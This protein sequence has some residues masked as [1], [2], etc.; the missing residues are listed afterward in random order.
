M[1]V[2]P[3]PVYRIDAGTTFIRPEGIAMAGELIA[4]VDALGPRV[5]LFDTSDMSELRRIEGSK[6]G[7]R[8]P[9][10]ADIASDG[11]LAVADRDAGATFLF[12]SGSSVP[13]QKL[14]VPGASAVAF[15]PGTDHVATVSHQRR[16]VFHARATGREVYELRGPE[17]VAP[18][19]IAV[20]SDGRLLAI[21]NHDGPS[22][23]IYRRGEQG[24]FGATPIRTIGKSLAYP[25]SLAF[26]ADGRGLFV[27]DAGARVVSLFVEP[28]PPG[29][30]PSQSVEACTETEF[31]GMNRER[32]DEGGPKGIAVALGRLAYVGPNIG[33]RIHRAE[34]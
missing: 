17:L 28:W 29:C 18:D 20:S 21:A 27:S 15:V 14:R 10:D 7:L 4:I 11:T 12:A 24:R 26:T 31:R 32:R 22:V 1:Q 33:L 9:H 8:Y 16:V 6:D 13:F 34:A 25:H 23:T 19:G 3:N 5:V 30:Q 2:D